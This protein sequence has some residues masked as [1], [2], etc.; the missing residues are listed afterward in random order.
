MAAVAVHCAKTVTV[1]ASGN[2]LLRGCVRLFLPA[3]VQFIATMSPRLDD[4]SLTEQ[5][6]A[7]IDEVWKM[8]SALLALATE[9]QRKKKHIFV[10]SHQPDTLHAGT[11]VLSIVLPTVALLL[12]PSQTIPLTTHS[13]AVAQLLTFAT[14]SPVSFKEA[15]AQLDPSVRDVLELSIRRA[16]EG[17]STV[18][19]A[20]ARPQ[21]SLRSF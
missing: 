18:G 7:S 16:V 11:R 2:D 21:I 14:L 17:T 13:S 20:T 10:S 19:Q 3:M 15:T 9:E 6:S 1:A 4:G 12:R 8:F 5:H